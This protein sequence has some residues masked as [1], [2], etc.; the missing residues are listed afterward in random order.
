MAI[1]DLADHVLV[2]IDH[3][4]EEEK[5]RTAFRLVIEEARAELFRFLPHAEVAMKGGVSHGIM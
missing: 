3:L 5:H 2:R 4:T 1:R